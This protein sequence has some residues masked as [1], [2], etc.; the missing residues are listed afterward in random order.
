M[1]NETT[2]ARA[3]SIQSEIRKK[4]FKDAFII[5]FYNGKRISLQEARELQEE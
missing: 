3:K 5:A 2:I 1:G 4:G